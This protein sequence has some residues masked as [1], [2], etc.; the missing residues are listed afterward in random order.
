M[1]KV[2]IGYFSAKIA[3]IWKKK[4]KKNIQK[5]SPQKLSSGWILYFVYM[6]LIVAST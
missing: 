4:P 2:E 6:F 3:D 5:S 1:G